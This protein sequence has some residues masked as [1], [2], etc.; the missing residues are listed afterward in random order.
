MVDSI[1]WRR[2]KR[3]GGGIL[4]VLLLN[5]TMAMAAEHHE[6]HGQVTFG[7]F[8]VPG[9]TVTVTQ[10]VKQL[11]T[12]TDQQGVYEFAD[13]PDGMWAVGWR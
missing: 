7:G 13:L 5:A 8:P 12:T 6:H 11:S 4:C 2:V 1:W 9:A 3:Y 10:G